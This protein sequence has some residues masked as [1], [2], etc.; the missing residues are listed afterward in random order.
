MSVKENVKTIVSITVEPPSSRNNLDDVIDTVR[1]AAYFAG[2]DRRLVILDHSHPLNFGQRIKEVIDEVDVVRVPKHYGA[3]GGRYKAESHL[4]QHIFAWYDFQVLIRMESDSLLTGPGLADDALA[5]MHANPSAGLLGAYISE[6][7]GLAWAREQLISMT[8]PS[9]FVSDSKRCALLRQLIYKAEHHNWRLGQHV[10]AG[11]LILT[12]TFVDR[13]Q[14]AGLLHRDELSRAKLGIDHIYS[15]LC[16]ACGL[17]LL[18]FSLPKGPLAVSANVL[19]AAPAD[20]LEHG[21]KLVHSTYEWQNMD[22][23]QIR[24]MFRARRE[25]SK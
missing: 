3:Y 19:M 11:G 24:T 2:P 14:R 1:S 15:L 6:G 21:A 22:E 23:P 8:G 16:K 12:P 7:E 18:D 20:L 17:D 5:K 13:V 25:N 9:G 4:L 10:L